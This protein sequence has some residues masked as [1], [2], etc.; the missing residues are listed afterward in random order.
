MVKHNQWM[1]IYYKVQEIG[2]FIKNSSIDEFGH[3]KLPIISA[4]RKESLLKEIRVLQSRS[5]FYLSKLKI[6]PKKPLWKYKLSDKRTHASNCEFIYKDK[7]KP[8]AIL[9]YGEGFMKYK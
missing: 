7:M 4:K 8:Q 9:K 3:H 2:L 5:N 6:V 1:K